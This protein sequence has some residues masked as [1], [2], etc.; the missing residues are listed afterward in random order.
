MTVSESEKYKQMTQTPV[1]K[2][3]GK[4]AVPSIIS[5]LIT[6]IYNMADTFFI[7]KIGTSASGAVGVAF[8]MMAVIQAL[9]FFFGQGAGNNI[10]R[11][12]GS[13]QPEWA[14]TLA[15]NGFFGAIAC[16]ALVGALGLVFLRPF[17]YF[18]GA[19]DTIY[20]YAVDYLRLIL[21]GA[22]WMTASFVLNNLLR[23]Q[24][25]AFYGMI[26]LTFGGI[27]NMLLDPLFIFTFHMGISG[28]ALA[29]ILS[30]AVSF[31]ILL[32]MCNKMGSVKISICNFQLRWAPFW[33]IFRGGLPS[34]LRQSIASVA[35]ICV[36]KAAKPF[37]D[38]AIAAMGI[39]SRMAMFSNSAL[40]GFGQGFQPVCGYN[41][42]AR[43]YARVRRG[44]WFCIKV[45]AAMLA[46][47][48]IVEFVFAEP[49]VALF[50]KG[51]PLVTQIGAKALR[52]QAVTLT[53]NCVL[54]IS[55]MMLQTTGMTVRASILG[56]ARQGIFLIPAVY[57]LT[58]AFGLTG[59]Q[60][61]QPVADVL[62]FLLAFPMALSLLYQMKRMEKE[63]NLRD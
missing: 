5:M 47:L 36:N 25:N 19:T 20:P 54:I 42:G 45:G 37:G 2:L 7:G 50:R 22:P 33:D 44:F 26:G 38:A 55:N 12:M 14:K 31:A 29:T 52:Y 56:V 4:L 9:G 49:I 24:G 6:A 1:E 34:L 35:T 48:S 18:L 21:I 8:S 10:S 23:F 40:I 27:L 39:I 3:I 59:L 43:L 30:Q 15:A 28:A 60:L 51:D 13:R 16:G 17:T 32:V 57:L 53:L 62:S 58:G 63:G 41:Y 11:A 46:V 61:A